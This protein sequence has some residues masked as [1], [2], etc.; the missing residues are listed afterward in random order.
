[1][2]KACSTVFPDPEKAAIQRRWTLLLVFGRLKLSNNT[3]NRSTT[4][5]RV[6]LLCSAAF[7]GS[8]KSVMQAFNMHWFVQETKGIA[9]AVTFN[10][11]QPILKIWSKL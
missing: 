1:M 8:E 11:D 6:H 9:V 4:S 2:L 10:D 5:S 7:A 3:K